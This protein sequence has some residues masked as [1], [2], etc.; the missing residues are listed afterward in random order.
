MYLTCD[1]AESAPTMKPS[2]KSSID[3]SWYFAATSGKSRA[4]ISRVR[5]PAQSTQRPVVLRGNDR[6]ASSRPNRRSGHAWQ[7]LRV[8]AR[9]NYCPPLDL[10]KRD[11]LPFSSDSPFFKEEK[12][13]FL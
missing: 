4:R 9:L 5:T 10:V 11:H 13:A 8:T 7:G 1:H 12:H 3:L 2:A 6:D